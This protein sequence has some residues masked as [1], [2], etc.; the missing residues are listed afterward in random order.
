MARHNEIGRWGEAVARDYLLG[1]GYAVRDMNVKVGRYEIDIVAEKDGRMVFV[2]V[3]TRGDDGVDPL[4]A[5]DGRRRKR[6]ARAADLYIQS[7]ATVL[8]PQFDIV[9]VV[10]SPEG[11]HVVEHFADAF[12]PPLMS[13]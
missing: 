7:T 13:Y 11:G 9:T 8:E 12:Y 6:L 5:V 1:L 10:G 3:K 2:E 4:D